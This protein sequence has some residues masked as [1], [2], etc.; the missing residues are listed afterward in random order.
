VADRRRARTLVR[1]LA[2]A[3]ASLAALAAITGWALESGGVLV[4]ET[5]S[6]D[7]STR[8]T[9]VWYAEHEGALWLEAGTPE[10]GWFVDVRREPRL[11]VAAPSH[12]AGRYAVEILATPEAHQRIRSLLRAKYALRDRWIELLFD[13]SRSVAVR[14][15][16]L[17]RPQA[18]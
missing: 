14:L 18:D 5:A 10:N 1:L 6:A 15:V 7:G 11:A 9:H 4:V 12:L 17:A 13:T 8:S 3:L 2:A 16:P